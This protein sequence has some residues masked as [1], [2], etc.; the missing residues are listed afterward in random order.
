M[1]TPSGL[2]RRKPNTDRSAVGTAGVF[3]SASKQFREGAGQGQ[4]TQTKPTLAAPS[5]SMRDHPAISSSKRSKSRHKT[6][7]PGIRPRKRERRECE[8][9]DLS[10]PTVL[11]IYHKIG[12]N[13]WFTVSTVNKFQY[14][15]RCTT[16]VRRNADNF[17]DPG[18]NRLNQSPSPGSWEKYFSN[19]PA[20]SS[21]SLASAGGSFLAVILG[22][23]SAYSAFTASQFSRPG[24]VSGRIAS[25]GHSGSQTPQSMHSSGWMTS[26]FSPS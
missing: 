8:Q 15:P 11:L 20:T 12:K 14:L 18:S 26:I 25:I 10:D 17:D 19:F 2:V 13:Q 6:S 23:F 21:N 22:H 1:S 24:S 9:S 7:K 4:T 5:P 3:L 16:I